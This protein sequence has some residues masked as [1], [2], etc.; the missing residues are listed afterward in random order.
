MIAEKLILS[1]EPV[2]IPWAFN[3]HG[4]CHNKEREN[5]S[6]HLNV[7][8]DAINYQPVNMNQFMKSGALNKIE[9]L[10][11]ATIDKAARKKHG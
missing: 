5:D 3:I 8:A 2:D 9:T 4:H 7:C 11:R 10:H 1:H 6:H